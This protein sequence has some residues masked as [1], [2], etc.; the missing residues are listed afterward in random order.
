MISGL[1]RITVKKMYITKF[2]RAGLILGKKY[3]TIRMMS[4]PFGYF[5]INF[6]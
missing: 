3:I 5:F 6:F 2:S 4:R 1:L